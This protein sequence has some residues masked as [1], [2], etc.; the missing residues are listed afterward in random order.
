[1]L[2]VRRTSGSPYSMTDITT[3]HASRR[4]LIIA[5]C[6]TS[7]F[8]VIQLIGAYY[9]NSLAVFADAGHLFVHNSSLLIALIASAVAIRV[10]NTFHDGYR[11]TE[12]VGS[13]MNGLLY[14]VIAGLIVF[15][16]A[17]RV[18]ES[19]DASHHVNTFVMTAV[20][21]LGFLFHSASA[22]VLYR[23]RKA[24]I[25]VYA[26]FLHTFF[27]LLSTA[28]T[29]VASIVIYFTQWQWVDAFSSILIAVFVLITGSRLVWQCA[30]EL[31]FKAPAEPNLALIE[32]TILT[33]SH[34]HSVHNLTVA[35]QK[36]KLV[37]G[38]HI[39]MQPGCTQQ[40]H[41]EVCR[42]HIEHALKSQFGISQCVL[43][44]EAECTLHSTCQ[45]D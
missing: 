45:G 43:Q 4:R 7:T 15:E 17:H 6:I 27:D 24:S 5:L 2:G 40:G 41:E 10:A 44:I 22:Y 33:V 11:K 28:T 1:M 25:N 31:F 23:G 3:H 32:Q 29:F 36:R 19:H 18:F 26:V 30:N 39:V 38:A 37:L 16:G 12:L 35:I 8:M 14:F 42:L 34:V 21:G 9:A 20:S 13:L